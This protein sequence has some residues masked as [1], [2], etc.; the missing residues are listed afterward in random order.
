M[1]EAFY[2]VA[3]AAQ[4]LK[5]HERTI[6]RLIASGRLRAAKVGKQYRILRSDLDSLGGTF[7]PAASP[8]ELARATSI[9]DIPAV[10]AEFAQRC[11]VVLPSARMG[12]EAA[13]NQMNIEITYDPARRHLKV[14]LV[15]SP[16]ETAAMLGLLS[17][18]L[19]QAR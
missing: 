9:V 15:G 14:V 7:A 2:T 19:Q 4:R 11:A 5:L 18:W 17:V 12:R 8:A 1:S 10:D 16:A 3:E 6:L 13:G